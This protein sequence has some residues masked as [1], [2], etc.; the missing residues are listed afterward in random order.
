MERALSTEFIKAVYYIYKPD[1][2][3]K[4]LEAPL[5]LSKDALVKI[6]SK[7]YFNILKPDN[8]LAS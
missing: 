8:S 7:S 1:Y 6:G 5:V 3:T 2:Y 4:C